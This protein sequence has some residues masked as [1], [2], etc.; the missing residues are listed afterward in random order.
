MTSN[1]LNCLLV[2]AFINALVQRFFII[3]ELFCHHAVTLHHT[4][5][6]LVD[7]QIATRTL[8]Y[9]LVLNN[10]AAI[11]FNLFVIIIISADLLNAAQLVRRI[12]C[13]QLLTL[14]QTT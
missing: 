1:I 13:F 12:F 9:A 4:D 8:G 5:S 6:V 2:A 3:L 7:K 14:L 11:T 10:A